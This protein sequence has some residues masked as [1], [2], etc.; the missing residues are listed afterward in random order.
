[1]RPLTGLFRRKRTVVPRR[2]TPRLV[3]VDAPA[4]RDPAPSRLSYRIERLWLTPLF[5]ATMRVGIPSFLAILALGVYLADPARRDAL[6]A[7]GAALKRNIEERPEFMVTLVSIDG[8]SPVVAEAVRRM[9]SVKVPVSSFH[10]DLEA[11]RATLT[12]VD[13]VAAADLRIKAGGVLQID[14]TER[15]PAVLWRTGER[16][17]MLD[18]TGHRVATLLN[19][20]ARPDLPMLA[21]DGADAAVPEALD[22]LAAVKPLEGRVR[23]LVRVGERRWNI[24]LDRDQTIMLPEDD[25]VA[26]VSRVVALDG[27]QDLLNRDVV[28]IDLRNAQRPTL[29]LTSAAIA[30]LR[31]ETD[32]S[33]TR[34]SGP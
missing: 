8:A 3:A 10:L 1:M 14:I 16:V 23:G 18:A 32:E 9:L 2:V 33:E 22:I 26:A 7:H 27:A 21:G 25:A 17:E 28:A 15:V 6:V 11:L 24:V 20:E 4:R 34:V 29:R 13:A 19:R 5:R 31:G 12:A 30:D